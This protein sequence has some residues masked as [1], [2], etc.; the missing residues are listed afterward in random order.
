MLHF[1]SH[2]S[3]V[4][5]HCRYVHLC[6]FV[7]CSCFLLHF[8]RTQFLELFFPTLLLHCSSPCCFLCYSSRISL[9]VL[10]FML[11]LWR[12]SLRVVA[13]FALLLF[14]CCCSSCTI[15]LCMLLLLSCCSLCYSFQ[16][17]ARVMF[18]PCGSSLPF[19]V[20]HYF[21]AIFFALFLLH[22]SLCI[23]P[24]MLQLLYCFSHAIIFALFLV[25]HRTLPL[26]SCSC[27]FCVAALPQPLFQHYFFQVPTSLTPIVLLMLLLLLFL[28]WCYF[29][30]IW[31]VW[32]F[33][34]TFAMCK[35]E[36]G[37]LTLT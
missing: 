18:L 34:P 10:L 7:C 23:A 2:L 6:L 11:F 26:S 4:F 16:T 30:F 36:L 1:L 35:L 9:L 13:L 31:L 32:Y 3:F 17:I 29:F 28:L 25:A 37:A 5:Q 20:C 24:C 8:F 22:Y 12:Y 19:L 14:T 21:H 27:Y 15:T 33:P